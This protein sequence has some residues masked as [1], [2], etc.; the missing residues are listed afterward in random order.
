[1]MIDNN[2][3]MEPEVTENKTFNLAYNIYVPRDTFQSDDIPKWLIRSGCIVMVGSTELRIYDRL[4]ERNVEEPEKLLMWLLEQWVYNLDLEP[5]NS[6][7]TVAAAKP[8]TSKST[9]TVKYTFPTCYSE[10]TTQAL[11]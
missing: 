11:M 9:E 6:A 7:Q 1:M 2:S 10:P 4:Y 8:C 3:V 5:S